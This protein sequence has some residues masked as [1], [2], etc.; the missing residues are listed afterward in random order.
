MFL[1][2]FLKFDSFQNYD[3]KL[4]GVWNLIISSN[5]NSLFID[6]EPAVKLIYEVGKKVLEFNANGMMNEYENN[7][8]NSFECKIERD[9][10]IVTYD[11]GSTIEKNYYFIGD[12]LIIESYEGNK[13]LKNKYIKEKFAF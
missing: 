9:N 7:K 11:N 13:L 6:E 4:Y 10:I 2:L 8:S 3:K 1:I 5:Y 12:T